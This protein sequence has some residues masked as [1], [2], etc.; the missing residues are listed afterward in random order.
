MR[1]PRKT[2]VAVVALLALGL[3]WHAV[4]GTIT[5]QQAVGFSTDGPHLGGAATA[6]GQR[7]RLLDSA[8]LQVTNGNCTKDFQLGVSYPVGAGFDP[9]ACAGTFTSERCLLACRCKA[10]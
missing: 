2:R 4:G 7:R 5:R 10:T 8:S 3:A 1:V 6:A 9:S